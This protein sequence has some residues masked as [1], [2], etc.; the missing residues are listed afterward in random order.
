ML[1][2]L[3]AMLLLG[4]IFFHP[5]QRTGRD[6][7][8][9]KKNHNL[10]AHE[11]AF[12]ALYAEVDGFRLSKTARSTY[13]A[14]E[15]LYGEIEFTAFI[16]L[17]SLCHLTPETRFCDLG[18][19]IGKAVLACA[20][21][22]GVERSTGVEMFSALHNTAKERVAI[23]GQDPAYLKKATSITFIEGDFLNHDLQAYTVIFIQATAF[24]GEYWH[25]ISH[26]LENVLPGTLIISVGKAI[27]SNQFT[28][29]HI[30]HLPM[31]WGTVA[32][33]IQQKNSAKESSA[34]NLCNPANG[35]CKK[36]L[37]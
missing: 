3:F 7:K 18:S 37:N 36:K 1:Y 35:S 34:K 23:L 13:D 16:A 21:V 5:Y 32:A 10:V 24:F 27:K 14:P 11:A 31:S 25:K 33:H 28:P 20:M 6:I 26:A 8:R 19:G 29:L 2:A 22:Y 17:L 12:N 15:Y 9:W 4:G 30:T